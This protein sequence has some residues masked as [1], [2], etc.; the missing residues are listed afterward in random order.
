MER[1]RSPASTSE[2]SAKAFNSVAVAANR[3]SGTGQSAPP[4]ATEPRLT[5]LHETADVGAVDEDVR[6]IFDK[7]ETLTKGL[8]TCHQIL[9]E[10]ASQQPQL[11]LDEQALRLDSLEERSRRVEAA[12]RA[13]SSEFAGVARAAG[14]QIVDRVVA[15]E[16]QLRQ[17][18]SGLD[19]L[20]AQVAGVTSVQN[21]LRSLASRV[22]A[23]AEDVERKPELT[24]KALAL[25]S[26]S[27]VVAGEEIL[28]EYPIV[29]RDDEGGRTAAMHRLSR[30][31]DGSVLREIFDV[32][33][34][35]VPLVFFR[36]DLTLRSGSV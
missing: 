17:L 5:T 32:E 3:P 11:L 26:Q 30:A 29:S 35:G 34:S 22:T 16:T 14:G 12:Q 13:L 19:E 33:R 4:N 28:L 15:L 27:G 31:G 7:I 18:L 25:E 10:R 20:S 8:S 24:V 21:Q 23:L 36:D 2:I 6:Q 1:L 9:D